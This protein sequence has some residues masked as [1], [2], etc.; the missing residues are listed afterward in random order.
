[1]QPAAVPQAKPDAAPGAIPP[2]SLPDLMEAFAYRPGLTGSLSAQDKQAINAFMANLG[3]SVREFAGQTGLSARSASALLISLSAQAWRHGRSQDE[4]KEIASR[5]R[6]FDAALGDYPF[7]PEHLTI[8]DL[9]DPEKSAQRVVTWSRCLRALDG[10]LFDAQGHPSDP[11]A[12][13][14]IADML[15]ENV[16]EE[17]A[18][19]ALHTARTWMQPSDDGGD[20][21]P[22]VAFLSEGER[23]TLMY[24]LA[25]QVAI[26][27]RDHA[28]SAVASDARL[29]GDAPDGSV[30]AAHAAREAV[31]CARRVERTADTPQD[32]RTYVMA[33]CTA[34]REGM[35]GWHGWM[36]HLYHQMHGTGSPDGTPGRIQQAM[37]KAAAVRARVRERSDFIVD[38]VTLPAAQDR[39]SAAMLLRA[40]LL[41]GVLPLWTRPATDP[42]RV[43]MLGSRTPQD[44]VLHMEDG[45]FRLSRLMAE[46]AQ[47]MPR[48]LW[49]KTYRGV[50]HATLKVERLRIAQ[51]LQ[52][53]GKSIP[54]QQTDLMGRVDEA[55]RKSTYW[56]CKLLGVPDAAHAVAQWQIEPVSVAP[57]ER[58]PNDR[59]AER[60]GTV[61]QGGPASAQQMSHRVS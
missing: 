32:S 47:E 16:P 53:G 54:P 46:H 31:L 1:M 4:I 56:A 60:P 61:A 51:A 35:S 49:E 40:K 20:A 15:H 45:I 17:A 59:P 42:L 50:A 28:A 13:A 44:A 19:M 26:A 8:E 3:Q 25:T 43:A 9:D 55:L 36:R 58:L 7:D 27:L 10:S 18:G 41:D 2:S 11:A 37:D 22:E 12:S 23:R 21:W 29:I 24:A 30:I 52:S 48:S 14:W 39:L 33:V 57:S 38:A 5:V 6:Q 34:V